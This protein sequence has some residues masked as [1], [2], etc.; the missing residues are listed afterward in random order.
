M[1]SCTPNVTHRE[2]QLN[3]VRDASMNS[4][5]ADIEQS[6]LSQQLIT[7]MQMTNNLV[8]TR[9][10]LELPQPQ[11]IHVR[12]HHYATIRGPPLHNK[13][14]PGLCE[15]RHAEQTVT[16]CKAP[17]TYTAWTLRPTDECNNRLTQ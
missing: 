2:A 1:C 10:K 17:Y 14:R 12:S 16:D 8:Q 9:F 11:A 15:V 4:H 5:T 7:N 6:S 3:R 13:L